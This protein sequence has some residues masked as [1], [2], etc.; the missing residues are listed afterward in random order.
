MLRTL[1]CRLPFVGLLLVFP[2]SAQQPAGPAVPS[3]LVLARSAFNITRQTGGCEY[4]EYTV[5]TPYPGDDVLSYVSNELHAHG[6]STLKLDAFNTAD[7]PVSTKWSAWKNVQGGEVHTKEAQWQTKTGDVVAYKFWYFAPKM[8]TL[9]VEARSCSAAQ[10]ARMVHHVHCPAGDST[11]LDDKVFSAAV[12]ITKMDPTQD[13][14]RVHFRIANTGKQ[15][16]LIG[17]EG[18]WPDGNPHLLTL[19][20]QQEEEHGQWSSVGNECVEHPP[21]SWEIVNPGESIESWIL[22][23]NFPEPNHHFGM[24]TRRVAKLN[25]HV[26]VSMRYFRN[27]CDIQNIF[28]S[29]NPLFSSSDAVE[30][31]I[32]GR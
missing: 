11:P 3:A 16:V 28:E 32:G 31:P 10:L 2:T 20:V 7:V 12:S 29:K 25:G 22:A 18:K 23:V 13:G 30:L 4:L 26:R 17:S 19:D 27:I 24:C 21:M 8:K 9:Q 14:Y 6:W 1:L 15:A 5:S